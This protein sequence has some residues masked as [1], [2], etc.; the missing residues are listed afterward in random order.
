MPDNVTHEKAVFVA[1]KS[2][3]AADT[4]AAIAEGWMIFDTGDRLHIERVDEG[5]VF[6]DDD[7]ARAWVGATVS[8]LHT[9]ALNV[10]DAY[11]EAIKG[12]SE[13]VLNST[14]IIDRDD[15]RDEVVRIL[16]EE[17]HTLDTEDVAAIYCVVLGNISQVA[18]VELAEEYVVLED[19]TTIMFN[20]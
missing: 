14:R 16:T 15:A 5:A 2:W 20:A 7:T 13:I 3:S 11:Q 19:E 12:P 1:L 10:I 9:K 17:R 4:E 18:R 8:E 6:P